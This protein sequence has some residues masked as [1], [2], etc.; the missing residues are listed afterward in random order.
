MS[1]RRIEGNVEQCG[2]ESRTR[3]GS[4]CE[5]L[6]QRHHGWKAFA[7]LLVQ[8]HGNACHKAPIID[9]PNRFIQRPYLPAIPNKVYKLHLC[10]R[11]QSSTSSLAFASASFRRFSILRCCRSSLIDPLRNTFPLPSAAQEA[12]TQLPCTK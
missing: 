11:L 4:S 8:H 3:G 7:S 10:P 2:V 9:D 5:S 1:W 12:H 6:E